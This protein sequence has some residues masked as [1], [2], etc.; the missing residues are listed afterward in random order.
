[1]PQENGSKRFDT[2][3][4]IGG[5]WL[6]A[7][8]LPLD[9]QAMQSVSFDASLRRQSWD[10]GAGFVRIARSLSTVQGGYISG[11]PMLHW[12]QVL[13]LPTV[14]VMGGKSYASAD[15]TGYNYAG[16]GG[17]IGHVPRYSYSDGAAFGG[18]VGLAIEVPLYRMIGARAVASQWYFTGDPLE[19][20][21]MRTVLGAGLSVRFGR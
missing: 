2:G 17:V 13:F 3:I 10:I 15:T 14:G 4:V 18:S 1:M 7:N 5:D 12:K 19:G 21:R 20:D 9:R 11:G 6:Q 16:A 8:A